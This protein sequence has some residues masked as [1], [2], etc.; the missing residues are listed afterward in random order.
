MHSQTC[1]RTRIIAESSQQTRL[2]YHTNKALTCTGSPGPLVASQQ[3]LKRPG[4]LQVGHQ[5]D[6][7]RGMSPEYSSLTVETQEISPE[8][9]PI[10]ALRGCNGVPRIKAACS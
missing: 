10:K 5:A 8:S 9:L 3:N 7:Q 2:E 1:S 4:V 6:M